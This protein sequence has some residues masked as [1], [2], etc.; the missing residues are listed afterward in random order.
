[1][2]KPKTTVTTPEIEAPAKKGRGLVLIQKTASE[3]HELIGADTSVGV[4]RKELKA[5]ILAA[6]AK[7]VLKGTGL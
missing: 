1:M 5:L 2:A 7:D 6:R 4:S 3:I